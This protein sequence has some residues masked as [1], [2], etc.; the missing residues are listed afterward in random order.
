MLTLHMF[1][2]G[3]DSVKIVIL[4][5]PLARSSG[6]LGTQNLFYG[7]AWLK[8]LHDFNSSHINFLA[9]CIKKKAYIDVD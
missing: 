3:C 2:Y 4:Y 5:N 6:A 7:V 9:E 1:L 8:T